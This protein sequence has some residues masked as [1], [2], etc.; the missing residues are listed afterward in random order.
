VNLKCCF[1]QNY[2]RV[3]QQKEFERVGGTELIKT[4]VRIISA[5]NRD[6]KKAVENKEFREDLYYRL[7]SFPI[8]IPPFRHRKSDILILSEHFVQKFSAKLQKNSKGFSKRALKLIYEYN[9]PGNVRELENTI[10][11]CLIITDKDIID[12][13]DLP[14]HLRTGEN[15]TGVEYT[16]PLFSDETVIPFE[17]LKEESIRHALNITNGNIVEA[18]KRLQLGRATIYRLMDKYKIENRS[19]E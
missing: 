9:W 1:K 17:K 2:L 12:V 7:N 4:D 8:S 13:E 18:A 5:T 14:A 19:S 16:G 11:R 3:I 6:L 10:E 15:N